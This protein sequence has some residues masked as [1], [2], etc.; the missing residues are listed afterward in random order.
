MFVNFLYGP[1]DGAVGLPVA[2]VG[3]DTEGVD[4][5]RLAE[6]DETLRGAEIGGPALLDDD[7][8]GEQF[9]ALHADDAATVAPCGIFLEGDSETVG[10][11]VDVDPFG[12]VVYAPQESVVVDAY[13]DLASGLGSDNAVGIEPDVGGEIAHIVV[14]ADEEGD[15]DE[16]QDEETTP[17]GDFLA[18]LAGR[19]CNGLRHAFG[20]GL[21]GTSALCA[22]VQGVDIFVMTFRTIFHRFL[23]YNG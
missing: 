21:Q 16:E 18:G 12:A 6:M 22:E 11:A 8:A 4:A 13:L 15:K 23:F 10:M 19:R 1:V 9:A 7:H 2:S 14:T 20:L 17:D 5:S 3:A